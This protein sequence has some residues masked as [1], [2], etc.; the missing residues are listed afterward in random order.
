V[1]GEPV[2]QDGYHDRIIRDER[3]LRRARQYI[4]DNLAKWAEDE[5]NPAN[6]SGSRQIA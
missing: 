3:G 6:A 4:H 5:Y 2:W 1:P